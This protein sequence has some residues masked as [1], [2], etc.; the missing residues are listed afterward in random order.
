MAA[1]TTR[2]TATASSAEAIKQLGSAQSLV[3]T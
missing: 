3:D 1:K 2:T